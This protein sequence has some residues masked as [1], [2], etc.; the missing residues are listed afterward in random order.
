MSDGEAALQRLRT[1]LSAR[2]AERDWQRRT[3]WLRA[4]VLIGASAEHLLLQFDRG[5]MHLDESTGP[6]LTWDFAL[7]ADASTWMRHW[8]APPA[9]G[10]HD[11]LALAK[12]DALRL[13]GD[14]HPF[15][16][17]LQFFKDLLAAPRA[18]TR[19]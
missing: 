5:Q 12:R 19:Q 11:L 7:R 2:Q 14:L 8:E 3:R 13:E 18:A 15:M 10:W 1:A 4:R 6:M 9:P 16:T 17:H